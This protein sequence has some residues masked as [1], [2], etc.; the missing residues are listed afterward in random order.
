M[1]TQP[2]PPRRFATGVSGL[3]LILAGLGPP[4]S[5]QDATRPMSITSPVSTADSLVGDSTQTLTD[6]RA[7][8]YGLFIHWGLY[9]KAE[10]QWKGYWVA[11]EGAWKGKG[12]TEFLQ[13]Q[14][15]VPV[16]EYEDFAR[17][18]R[19]AGF[20]AD[21]WARAA[22]AA[23]MRYLVFTTKHHEGFAMFR[24][25]SSG[26]NIVDHSGFA[27]DPVAEL[28]A[29]CRR[30][31]LLFGVYYSLGR[32]WHDPDA[33]TDWPT[34]GGR[35]NTWDYPDEDAKV[36]DRYFRRKVLPQVAELLTNYGPIPIFWFDTPEKITAGQSR[37][38]RELIRRLQPGCIVNDRVGNRLGDF[39]THEQT[40]PG[41]TLAGPWE[42]CATLGKNW[43]YHPRDLDWKT[44]EQIV[45]LLTDVVAKDGNL[46]FNI[47]PRGDG[48]FPPGAEARLKTVGDWLTVNGDAV[49]GARAWRVVGET[50]AAA[51]AKAASAGGTAVD[52]ATVDTVRDEISRSQE[53][54]LRYTVGAD[55]ALYVIVRSWPEPVVTAKALGLQ[56]LQGRRIGGVTLIGSADMIRWSQGNALLELEFPAL[57]PGV[58]PVWAFRVTFL[59]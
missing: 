10:G 59:E 44:P 45:R 48:T 1:A 52:V 41:A 29:A 20:D 17:G 35:S 50:R 43:G 28:A 14:A 5:A 27:F 8:R 9:S 11:T 57:R 18:F 32:D 26:F 47:G 51:P 33:P 37:E 6:W 46:L 38:L 31:G 3:A 39:E 21:A 30:H 40:V 58:I 56:N 16:R 25:A 42:S 7:A 23:G 22:R 13:L 15:R 53:A 54:D 24:S 19:P 4:A 36:F 49:Y 12:F 34:K 2:Y 55:G